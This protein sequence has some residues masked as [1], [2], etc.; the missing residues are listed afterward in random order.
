MSYREVGDTIWSNE[1]ETV[2]MTGLGFAGQWSW[3]YP[4]REITANGN[5]E[6]KLISEDADGFR[7]EEVYMIEVVIP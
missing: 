7:A 4:A 1:V 6:I 5:Y 3:V 2:W